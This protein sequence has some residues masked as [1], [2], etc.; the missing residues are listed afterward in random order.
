LTFALSVL[1]FDGRNKFITVFEVIA[2]MKRFKLLDGKPAP[3]V[4]EKCSAVQIRWEMCILCQ[5]DK[6]EAVQCPNNTQRTDRGTGYKSLAE[7]L[8][9]FD[10]KGQLPSRICVPDVN[11]GCGFE[12]ACPSTPQNGI[13]HVATCIAK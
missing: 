2:L 10:I 3:S 8:H 4:P 6:S 1:N 12:E 9:E 5:T 13:N 7:S 11:E